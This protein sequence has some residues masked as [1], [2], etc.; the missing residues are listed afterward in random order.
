[1]AL[2]LPTDP[3]GAVVLDGTLSQIQQLAT[4]LRF[5]FAYLTLAPGSSGP[6]SSNYA[7]NVTNDLNQLLTDVQNE[8]TRLQGLA[9]SFGKLI[10]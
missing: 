2:T 6:G 8:L 4:A 10:T 9:V 3:N 1:M 7:T 5:L